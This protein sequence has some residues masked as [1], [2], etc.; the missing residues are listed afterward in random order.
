[1]FLL[2]TG[3]KLMISDVIMKF[4]KW[5][6]QI[7]GIINLFI[8]LTVYLGLFFVIVALLFIKFD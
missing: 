6:R 5:K 7:W 1:M 2:L 3:A 4:A 8:I